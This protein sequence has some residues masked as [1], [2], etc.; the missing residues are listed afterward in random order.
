[1]HTAVKYMSAEKI[2]YLERLPQLTEHQAALLLKRRQKQEQSKSGKKARSSVEGKTSKTSGTSKRANEL[3]E[4]PGGG[5]LTVG[6]YSNSIPSYQQQLQI[7]QPHPAVNAPTPLSL[8]GAPRPQML[9]HPIGGG[10]TRAP[11]QQAATGSGGGMQFVGPFSGMP[12]PHAATG[13]SGGMPLAGP[14]G[15][16]AFSSLP[17]LV[18]P[19]VAAPSGGGDYLVDS[20]VTRLK[21][22]DPS[23]RFAAISEYTMG[24]GFVHPK[25]GQSSL[26]A[27]QGDPEK[28]QLA[29]DFILSSITSSRR[30][31]SSGGNDVFRVRIKM[32]DS[33]F[34]VHSDALASD[35]SEKMVWGVS[36][37][38]A[39][40]SNLA[41]LNNGT[42]S[43]AI[44]QYFAVTADAYGTPIWMCLDGE[45]IIIAD[46]NI[47]TDVPSALCA[48]FYM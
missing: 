48:T 30:I 17:P 10:G 31:S 7:Q 12:P 19:S 33:M 18:P 22:P 38:S 26:V 9:N 32:G 14:F 44:R 16:D 11:V 21:S 24:R 2:D 40:H 47:V 4:Q 3:G 27:L 35:A 34:F 6:P 15:V 8:P 1:M 46:T 23:V 25:H 41:A 43:S 37:D 45:K 5:L 39:S 20:F 42:V 36:T 28:L 13:S 29:S